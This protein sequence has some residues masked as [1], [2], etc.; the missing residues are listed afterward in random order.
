MS[1]DLLRVG[2]NDFGFFF[3]RL[4]LPA[5]PQ[6]R[7]HHQPH[8]PQQPPQSQLQHGPQLLPS[9][10]SSPFFLLIFCFSSNNYYFDH[11]DDH[12]DSHNND[13]DYQDS[14]SSIGSKG[15]KGT[16]TVATA[17]ARDTRHVSSCWYCY[18]LFFSSTILMFILGSLD[19][20]KWRW[21]Q[22]QHGLETRHV[23]IPLVVRF[24]YFYFTTV[25][26][27]FSIGPPD[28]SKQGS[29]EQQHEL[30]VRQ[31]GSRRGQQ[32]QQ[33]RRTTDRDK[34]VLGYVFLSF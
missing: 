22:Q 34:Q 9:T 8:Q 30:E 11:L 24:F 2:S 17:R 29:Q 32:V 33:G 13:H 4:S 14:S 15:S 28:T 31:Q 6:P 21:Q 26:L 1:C 25:T 18:F 27:M 19:T 10:V 7:P 20:S 3:L 23:S 16:A 5:Q 12:D